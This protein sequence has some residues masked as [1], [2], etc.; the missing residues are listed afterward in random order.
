MRELVAWYI[1]E[2]CRRLTSVD[3][4]SRVEDFLLETRTHIDE[5]VDEMTS[6]G[7]AE[8]DATKAAITDFGHPSLVASAFRGRRHMSPRTYW[9]LLAVTFLALVPTL[10]QVVSS[11]TDNAMG[12]WRVGT[13]DFGMSSVVVFAAIALVAYFS[14]RWCSLPLIGAALF[15][16]AAVGGWFVNRTNAYAV[17]DGSE[18]FV[19]LSPEAA[20]RQVESRLAWVKQHD[21]IAPMLSGIAFPPKGV[22]PM[23]RLDLV[24]DESSGYIVPMDMGPR[25]YSTYLW[26]GPELPGSLVPRPIA[27]PV[28]WIGL[29]ETVA[30]RY[31]LVRQEDKA[32][33]LFAWQQHGEAY[34]EQL[35]AQRTLAMREAESFKSPATVAR[36]Q[37]VSRLL[38]TPLAIVGLYSLLGLLANAVAFLASDSVASLSRMRWKRRFI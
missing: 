18:R 24:K 23:T 13:F 12:Y 3:P 10:V 21:R 19:M 6:R 32:A 4:Q 31:T 17:H 37:V 33:A 30:P 27:G 26:Y 36:D 29:E 9:I 5:S 22:D 20:K 7:I 11:S 34:L 16:T 1:V 2:L 28:R 8:E 35:R 15:V 38:W 14:R 25:S